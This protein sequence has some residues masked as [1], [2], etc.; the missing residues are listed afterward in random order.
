VISRGEIPDDDIIYK[1]SKETTTPPKRD[2]E[3]I[4]ST[5]SPN[6]TPTV[7]EIELSLSETSAD[8][9]NV[10]G[11]GKAEVNGIYVPYGKHESGGVQ[12]T[13]GEFIMYYRGCYSKWMIIAGNSNLY[14]NQI[15]SKT[16]PPNQWKVGCGEKELEPPPTVNPIQKPCLTYSDTDFYKSNSN[17]Y[18]IDNSPPVII[19][20]NNV[21][22]KT[23]SGKN[24]DDFVVDNKIIVTNLPTGL[25]PV[26]T[27]LDDNHL[28]V[29]FTGEILNGD[30]VT[31]LTFT[32]QDIA[33]SGGNASAVMNAMKEDIKI[34]PFNTQ[35]RKNQKP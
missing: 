21:S 18:P 35:K 5:G 11:A 1:N 2:W 12:Y 29:I 23:F 19:T 26:I 13:N 24:G 6:S 9:Y 34:I 3:L 15:D 30:E 16:P 20:L 14:K 28:S 33:F 4:S 17:L 27:R 25:K 8:Y 32:F 31:N 7:I 10:K 22:G